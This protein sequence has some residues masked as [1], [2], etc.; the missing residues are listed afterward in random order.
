MEDWEERRKDSGGGRWSERTDVGWI[1]RWIE[2]EVTK[3]RKLE[4]E[5]G[6]EEENKTMREKDSP[7]D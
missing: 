5:R 6:R 1:D 2:V 3:G 4:R 7:I